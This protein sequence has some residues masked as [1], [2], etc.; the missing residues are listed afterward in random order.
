MEQWIPKGNKN[1]F[2]YNEILLMSTKNLPDTIIQNYTYWFSISSFVSPT[3]IQPDNTNMSE[4]RPSI[5][6]EELTP[7]VLNQLQTATKLRW[8]M[9]NDTQYFEVDNYHWLVNFDI[10]LLIF[11]HN[12]KGWW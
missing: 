8:P 10:R 3:M 12:F 5:T 9:Y 6:A 7:I 1:E 11:W 2:C 4:K